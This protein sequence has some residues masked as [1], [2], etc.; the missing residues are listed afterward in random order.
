MHMILNTGAWALLT[1]CSWC[2]SQDSL[3][4]Q[5]K[6]SHLQRG[7]LLWLQSTLITLQWEE[8]SPD[9]PLR[10]ELEPKRGWF[11]TGGTV[12]LNPANQNAAVGLTLMCSDESSCNYSSVRLLNNS[13]I[14][15]CWVWDG[16]CVR[17][18]EDNNHRERFSRRQPLLHPQW[19]LCNALNAGEGTRHTFICKSRADICFCQKWIACLVLIS[20][21]SVCTTTVPSAQRDSYSLWYMNKAIIHT[22]LMHR[23]S[24]DQFCQGFSCTNPNNFIILCQ[25]NTCI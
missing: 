10:E 9:R 4:A 2:I 6:M 23:S 11:S 18:S 19:F 17:V 15:F 3:V 25:W 13:D 24:L 8:R 1:V 16:L 5:V 12:E 22:T 20:D 7:S 21:L 14:P